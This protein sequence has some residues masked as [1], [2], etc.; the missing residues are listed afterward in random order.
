[1]T[2]M[3][4]ESATEETARQPE[5]PAAAQSGRRWTKALSFKNI[6]A[7]YTFIGIVIVFSFWAPNTFPTYTTVAQVLNENSIT[8][9]MALS[10]IIPLSA[11]VFDLSIGYA[12]GLCNVL[13]AHL[14]VE[15]HMGPWPA[16]GLTLLCALAIGLLNA[17]VVVIFKIDSLIATLATG[18]LLLAGITIVSGQ[19]EIVGPGLSNGFFEEIGNLGVH[20]IDLPVFYMLVVAV[21]IWFVLERTVGGRWLYATGYNPDA[22]RLAGIPVNRLRFISLLVSAMVAGGI[23]GICVTSQIAAGSAT[24]GPP[25]LLNAFAAA[26]LGATQFRQ[27]RF[28]P[29]GTLV[30]VLLLGAGTTGL[31][32]ANAPSWAPEVFT[33]VVLL[34]ALGI[35]RA[36]RR[37][38]L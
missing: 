5:V 32:L 8:G 7:V 1:M 31:A 10:L 22:S 25:Y 18:S 36:E 14:I 2:N 29:W 6:G 11:G 33:G 37:A 35:T 20:G 38:S 3:E 23:A 17:V 13:V 26:F 34:V 28:N 4:R 30:A 12:L 9:L 27:G 16:I 19:T 15:N 21:I 24:V